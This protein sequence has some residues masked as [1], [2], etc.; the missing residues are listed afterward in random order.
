MILYKDIFNNKY[1]PKL[2]KRISI[3]Y[4]PYEKLLC[5]CTLYVFEDL[6]GSPFVF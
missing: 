2:M 5:S 6:L 3:G 1:E 4:V